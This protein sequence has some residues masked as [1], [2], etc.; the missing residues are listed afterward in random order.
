MKATHFA[1]AA[2]IAL[3]GAGLASRAAEMPSTIALAVHNPN[4]PTK[5]TDR[6]AA[7]KPVEVLNFA[8]V[9][10]GEQVL[11]LIPG[12]GYFTRLLSGAVG[13]TGHVTEAVPLVGGADMS[14]ASNGVAADPNFSN[15]SETPLGAD[16]FAK[17]VGQYDLVWTSQN[18]HDLHLTR[19]KLDVVALDRGIYAALKPGGEFFIE[20]HAAKPGADV[21]ATA[22]ALHRIDVD[23]VKKEVESVG[24]VL[25]RQSDIL[26]NPAD[27]HTLNVFQP[28]IR[29][30]TDQFLLVFK[31][32]K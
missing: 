19:L 26:R 21:T 7:R 30:H 18:Y 15:V 24:F 3:L 2:A 1:A 13:P 16:T 9:K 29:G 10:P 27:D 25:A 20:D 4:R 5:D 31:K 12:G 8:H 17:S 23:A 11:E 6:D 14:K 32:P 22:D 28:A